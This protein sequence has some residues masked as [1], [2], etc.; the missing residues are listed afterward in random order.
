MLGTSEPPGKKATR[1][2]YERRPLLVD[3]S[4]RWMLRLVSVVADRAARARWGDH[5]AF[6]MKLD[7]ED[8]L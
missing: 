6:T 5:K 8:S 1:R 3:A 2:A 4:N 7:E